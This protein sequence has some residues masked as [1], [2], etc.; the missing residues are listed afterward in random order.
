MATAPGRRVHG[1]VMRVCCA[2]LLCLVIFVFTAVLLA[3][4]LFSQWRP[5]FIRFPHRFVHWHQGP[6]ISEPSTRLPLPPRATTEAVYKFLCLPASVF[7]PVCAGVPVPLQIVRNGF[8]SSFTLPYVLRSVEMLLTDTAGRSGSSLPGCRIFWSVRTV[9]FEYTT[10][11][12]GFQ[13]S[14]RAGTPG[15]ADARKGYVPPLI[16]VFDIRI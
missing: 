5:V 16:A 7:S 4:H 9:S 2:L 11:T 12:F 8:P 1:L 15:L 3:R 10:V 13:V 14:P 6:E